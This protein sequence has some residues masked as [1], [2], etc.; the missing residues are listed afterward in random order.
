[1]LSMHVHYDVHMLH[2]A[3][4]AFCGAV[5]G[6]CSCFVFCQIAVRGLIILNGDAGA[7]YFAWIPILRFLKTLLTFV[8]TCTLNS[9]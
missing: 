6:F 1:M 3:K 4:H 7:D 8:N 2:D 9:V 5:P